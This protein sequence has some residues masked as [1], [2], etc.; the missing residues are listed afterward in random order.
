MEN[1]PHKRANKIKNDEVVWSNLT[2]EETVI[3][4]SPAYWTTD[5]EKEGRFFS[6]LACK[7]NVFLGNWLPPPSLVILKNA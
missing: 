6:I 7:E 3:V 2:Y 4:S 1:K 5:I